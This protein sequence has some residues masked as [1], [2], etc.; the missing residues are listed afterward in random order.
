[1]FNTQDI[2][3]S[4]LFNILFLKHFIIVEIYEKLQNLVNPSFQYLIQDSVIFNKFHL[5]IKSIFEEESIDICVLLLL[6]V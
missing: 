5:I 1:V 4:T 6:P 3:S 2:I